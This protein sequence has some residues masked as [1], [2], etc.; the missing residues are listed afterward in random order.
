MSRLNPHYLTKRQ[1]VFQKWVA[2][3][4]EFKGVG[5]EI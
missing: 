2:L 4:E 3:V 1:R 5:G